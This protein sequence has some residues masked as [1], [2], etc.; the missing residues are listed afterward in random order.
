MATYRRHA[1]GK[2]ERWNPYEEPEGT[3]TV[4]ENDEPEERITAGKGVFLFP[5]HWCADDGQPMIPID[6]MIE[7]MKKQQCP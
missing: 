3:W 4:C 2:T 6:K 1:D 5:A 7:A